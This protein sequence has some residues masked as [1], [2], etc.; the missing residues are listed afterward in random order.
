MLVILA[1][2]SAS[3]NASTKVF[4]KP[5]MTCYNVL[6]NG[7]GA[8]I[9]SVCYDSQLPVVCYISNDFDISCIKY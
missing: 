3:A 2:I 4:Q 9:R 8:Y 6:I 1:S 5:S 7:D